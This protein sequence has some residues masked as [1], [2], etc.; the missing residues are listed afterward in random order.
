MPLAVSS[1]CALTAP[2]LMDFQNS[3]VVP[4]GMTAMTKGFVA[5]ALLV[6]PDLVIAVYLP[7]SRAG[8]GPL[9]GDGEL[10]QPVTASNAKRLSRHRGIRMARRYGTGPGIQ[11]FLAAR[12]GEAQRLKESKLK[13]NSK[14]PGGSRICGRILGGH[15]RFHGTSQSSINRP[16]TRANSLTLW[17]TKVPPAARVIAAIQRSDSLMQAP[18]SSSVAR[19]ST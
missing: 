10:S 8:A 18:A 13:G 6:G 2:A 9:V 1:R 11:S 15:G 7:T 5:G 14:G 3:C 4:L 12:S 16:G 17:V 19:I